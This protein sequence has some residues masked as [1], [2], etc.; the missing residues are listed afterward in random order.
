M[1]FSHFVPEY[2]LKVILK[3]FLLWY[4][5]FN[6]GLFKVVYKEP[7]GMNNILAG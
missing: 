2:I 3:L 4:S 5:S 6:V 7:Q 1:N